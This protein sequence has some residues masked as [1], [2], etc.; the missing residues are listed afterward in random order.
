MK[1]QLMETGLPP[2]T[3][4]LFQVGGSLP[5]NTPIYVKRQADQDFYEGLKAGE[6][7]Y[8]LNSRQMG[9]SS[10]RVQT[11]QQLQADNIACTVI[12]LTRIGNQYITP[13]QWY[14]GIVRTLVSGF[15][16]TNRVNLRVWWRDRDHL[17]PV[18]RLSDFIE[19]V[20]LPAV[21]QHLVIFIDEIDSVLSLNFSISDFFALIRDCYNQ[22]ADNLAYRRLTFALLGVATPSDLIQDKTRTPFNIGQAIELRGFRFDEAQPLIKGLIG[23]VVDPQAVLKAV[24]DWTSG[25][26]FLTQKLCQLVSKFSASISVGSEAEGV[27]KLVRSHVIKNWESQDEP[28]HLRTIRD[29]LLA[30]DQHAELLLTIYQQIL[31]QQ[32]IPADD[33]PI[34]ME[35]R[36]SGVVAE[37]L[38]KLRVCNRIYESVF[39]QSWV[40]TA[41]QKHRLTHHH[42]IVISDNLGQRRFALTAPTYSIGRAST[43]DIRIACGFVSR[44]HATLVQ[45]PRDDGSSFYRIIDGNLQG[46]VSA[47]GL[48][49]NS[50]K[51]TSH[52]LENEDVISLGQNVTL[53]YYHS[54]GLTP[55]VAESTL[56]G[57]KVPC[58]AFDESDSQ[59]ETNL[60]R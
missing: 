46:K 33:S 39:D 1:T 50:R 58:E 55:E 5:A 7:C 54:I 28:E 15:D 36:L 44:H 22:R 17:S 40:D 31:Q 21:P 24:L 29:R 3:K 13:D 52:N 48:M 27:G 19:E 42:V 26:P 25:Q 10:L 45:L 51:C 56:D 18:Q 20:L 4:N 53:T 30:N 41:L 47:N 60:D 11:M 57:Y 16:L 49:A 8:V 9:K 32:E 59:K 34:Q 37:R 14:A 2:D 23:K 35:L 12:D 6:F 43:C 38:S